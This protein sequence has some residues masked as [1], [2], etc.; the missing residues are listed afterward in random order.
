MYKIIKKT[1]YLIEGLLL[2][3][4]FIFLKFLPL[5]ISS[6]IMGKFSAFIGPYL[7][8]SKKAF[9]NINKVMPEKSEK[10]IKK[11]IK[12][13]WENL[14]RVF[15]EYPHLKKLEPGINN[16]IEVRGKKN[17]HLINRKFH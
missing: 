16:K 3:I 17:L 5:N 14:G 12:D 13:M 10:E 6:F 8:I 4:I 2:L 1:I 11:I 15:G 9:N 7:G